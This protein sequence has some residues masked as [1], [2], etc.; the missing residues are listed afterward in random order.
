MADFSNHRR[1]T[2]RCLNDDLVPVSI[3]LRNNIRTPKGFQII[4][5]A[6]R[7]LLNERVRLINNTINMLKIQRDTC[8]DHLD[9]AINKE[10]M[11]ECKEFIKIRKESQHVKT[12]E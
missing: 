4:R 12:M 11:E 6:E 3:R 1:F 5:R 7:A 2:L 10:C 8:I 9:K